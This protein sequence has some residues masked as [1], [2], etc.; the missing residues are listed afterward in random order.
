MNKFFT[1]LS[2][3]ITF[4]LLYNYSFSQQYQQPK[5]L[6][7]FF[8]EDGNGARDTVY[9]G[10]DTTAD[11]YPEIIDSQ[12]NEG[13]QWIDTTKFNVY[14]WYYPGQPPWEGMHSTDSVR[15][16]DITSFPWPFVHVGFIKGKMP[17]TMKWKNS[18]LNSDSLAT[19]FPDISPRPR[20]RV[21]V[22]CGGGVP[23]VHCPLEEIPYILTDSCD[24]EF[25]YCFHDSLFWDCFSD[26]PPAFAIASLILNI[27]PHDKPIYGIEETPMNKNFAIVP[28]PFVDVCGIINNNEIEFRY[29][30]YNI[31][32]KKCFSKNELIKNKIEDINIQNFTNGIYFIRL[33]YRKKT[34]VIKLIKF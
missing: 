16:K 29:E 2:L 24:D 4:F 12:F 20:A 13:W 9:I 14:L 3:S 30:V 26:T 34:E 33:F 11:L 22:Y 25:I 23:G 21:D 27:V 28:N 15:K 7:P 32:G 6:M 1:I 17:I 5:W 8:F 10:I 19:W 31:Y 18:F